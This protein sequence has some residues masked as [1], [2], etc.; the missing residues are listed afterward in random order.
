MD[1]QVTTPEELGELVRSRRTGLGLTQ[2]DVAAVAM[3]TPRLLGEVERGKPTAQLNGVLRI[4][5][6]LGLDLFARP[7]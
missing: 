4:L 5:A 7:R 2:E 3:V 1:I 6:A